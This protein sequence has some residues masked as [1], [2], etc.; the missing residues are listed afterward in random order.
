VAIKHWVLRQEVDIWNIYCEVIWR[1][2][3]H[4]P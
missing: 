2:E 1:A 3:C 4:R